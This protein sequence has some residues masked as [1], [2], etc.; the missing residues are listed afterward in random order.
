MAAGNSGFFRRLRRFAVAVESGR[1]RGWYNGRA[2]ATAS[3]EDR[4]TALEAE[5]ARLR[6]QKESAPEPWWMTIR[7]DFKGDEVYSEAM[8]LGREWRESQ[9]VPTPED[10]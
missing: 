1:I 4:L 7:G 10:D 5:V 9:P 2:M 6:R 3:I 8:R